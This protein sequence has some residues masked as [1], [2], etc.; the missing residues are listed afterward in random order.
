ML[1]SQIEAPVLI[2]PVRAGK[3]TVAAL[4]AQHLALAHVSLDAIRLR[5]YREIGYDEEHARQLREREGF[6]GL[7]RYWKPFEAYAVERV[8]AEHRDAV[9][10]FG[11]GHS[12]QDD[13]R[14]F[15]R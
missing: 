15:A 9:V 11:A 4:L 8:L 3:T 12:V 14:L 1:P 13:P 6:A 2:G 5:Y 10:D 7:Y